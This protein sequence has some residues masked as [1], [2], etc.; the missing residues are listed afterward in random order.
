[1]IRP[2]L[3]ELVKEVYTELKEKVDEE[4]AAEEPRFYN[5]EEVSKMLHLSFPTM[6]KLSKEGKL[7]GKKINGRVL[8]DAYDIDLLIENGIDLRYNRSKN[9]I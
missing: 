7:K 4:R 2:F 5:R 1:M 3:K 9:L 6:W 8:Y